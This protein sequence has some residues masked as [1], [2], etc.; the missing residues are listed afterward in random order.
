MLQIYKIPRLFSI[1]LKP[2]ITYCRGKSS[3]NF[4][5]SKRS[6]EEA[7]YF[8]REDEELLTKI[9]Q[10]HPEL[11]PRLEGGGASGLEGGCASM[12]IDTIV[13]QVCLKHNIEPTPEFIK[14]L[15]DALLLKM[16]K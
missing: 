15:N 1:Q 5:D 11:D 12:R 2:S 4:V 16:D 7:V 3:I 14:D 9:L 6:G 8:R 10:K 13:K